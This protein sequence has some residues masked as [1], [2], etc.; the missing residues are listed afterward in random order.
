MAFFEYA[1]LFRALVAG[2]LAGLLAPIVGQFLVVRRLSLLADT[3]AHVSLVGVAA[4]MLLGNVPLLGAAIVAIVGSVGMEYLRQ[5]RGLSGES[6]LAMFLSGGLATAVVIASFSGSKS[7]GLFSYLFGSITTVS[8]TDVWAIFIVAVVVLALVAIFYKQLVFTS[9][10]EELAEANGLR[11]GVYGYVLVIL[12]ALSVVVAI[13]IVGVLLIGALMVIPVNA[14]I[15]YGL[16]FARTLLLSTTFSLV[17]V[18]AGLWT[19][20]RFDFPSGGMIVIVALLIFVCST[21]LAPKRS[22]V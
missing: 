5:S 19:S 18:A 17:S 1:F 13:R 22:R 12:A 10:S 6:V 3:L 21:I 9:W 16:G 7:A 11:S 4:G 15:Q 14:A 20:Y 2:L 8:Q